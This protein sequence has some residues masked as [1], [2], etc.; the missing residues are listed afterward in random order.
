LQHTHTHTHTHTQGDSYFL[1]AAEFTQNT[2]Q[3]SLMSSVCCVIIATFLFYCPP[4]V[5]RGIWTSLAGPDVQSKSSLWLNTPPLYY[6]AYY[7]QQGY[8]SGRYRTLLCTLFF[9]TSRTS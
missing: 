8:I 9:Q 1:P 6:V 7:E 2:V 3:E 4:F 5:R